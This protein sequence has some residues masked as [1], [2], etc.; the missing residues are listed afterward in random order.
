VSRIHAVI[1]G[2]QLVG[3]QDPS[4]PTDDK[5]KMLVQYWY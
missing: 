1:H 2:R 4:L 3:I 5:E